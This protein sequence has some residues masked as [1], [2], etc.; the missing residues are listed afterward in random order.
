M[1]QN[2]NPPPPAADPLAER[3]KQTL[4]DTLI[5][6]RRA[7]LLLVDSSERRLRAMGWEPGGNGRNARRGRISGNPKEG[8]GD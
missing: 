1:T 4:I 6:Q 7:G 3:L 5:E 8:N 2:H